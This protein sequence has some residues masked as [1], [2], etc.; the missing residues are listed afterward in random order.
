MTPTRSTDGE[1][2]NAENDLREALIEAASERLRGQG[3]DKFSTTK[4]AEDCDTSRQMIY[5]FFGGKSGLL[6][7]VF[8]YKANEL[9]E[10]FET[11]EADGP[12]DLFYQSGHVYR[13]FLLEHAA[14][15]D[16]VFS[17]E[18]LENYKGPK[19]LIERV[20]AHDYFESLL[21]EIVEDGLLP[22]DTD[23]EQL[24]DVLWGAVNGH[25]QL[26]M[27][28]YF[29]DEETAKDTYDQLIISI[30]NGHID[31]IDLSPT[32]D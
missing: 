25:V 15:Y 26:K 7:A 6:K 30:L 5:T 24:T 8:E 32:Q 20:E 11:I 19:K 12:L 1:S 10:R 27:L 13:D 4:V 14:L 22:E 17:L 2:S 16:T 21:E 3:A 31:D 28:N 9:K 29:P 23:V 18:A